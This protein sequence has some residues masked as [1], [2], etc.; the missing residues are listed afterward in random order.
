MPLPFDRN[1]P[2][3]KPGKRLGLPVGSL[4]VGLAVPLAL[5]LLDASPLGPELLYV[6]FGVPLLL[7]VWAI[8]GFSAAVH[9]VRAARRHAWRQSLI[10][11]VLPLILLAVA[12]DPLRVIWFCNDLGDTLHF[13]VMRGS[14]DRQIAALPETGEPRLLVINWGGMVWSSVGVVYD[15]SDEVALPP[16]EQSP[17]WVA[18]AHDTELSC[19]GFRIRPLWAHYYLAHFPC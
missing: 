7:F 5:I 19:E 12:V 13:V 6:L 9:S 16:G 11:A 2:A 10:A 15:E 8:A 14:Y 3:Q 4:A 17:A 1:A 18:R